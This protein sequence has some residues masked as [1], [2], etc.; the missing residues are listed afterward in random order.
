MVL[1]IKKTA[2]P[3]TLHEV[4]WSGGGVVRSEEVSRLAAGRGG[5]DAPSP[6]WRFRSR[7]GVTGSSCARPCRCR[8]GNRP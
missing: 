2:R 6:R 7:R 5:H 3:R 1:I 8:A 4:G